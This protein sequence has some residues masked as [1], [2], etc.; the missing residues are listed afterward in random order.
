VPAG[1]DL[2]VSLY[3]KAFGDSITD[4]WSSTPNTNSRWPDFLAR[5]LPGRAVVNQGISG[6]RILQDAFTS[7]GWYRGTTRPPKFLRRYHGS[8]RSR[9]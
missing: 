8:R 7:G 3:L 2:L 4:G 9:P 1:A 5:R 6:N